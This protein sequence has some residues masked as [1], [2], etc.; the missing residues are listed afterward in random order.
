MSAGEL[1]LLRVSAAFHDVGK[2]GIPDTVLLKPGP[3]NDEEWAI[4]KTHS[5]KCHNIMEA[6]DCDES[7][8]IGQAV[9]H[10]H[11]RFDG[12]GYPDGLAGEAIPIL[13]RILMVADTYDATARR[14]V[15]ATAK[16]HR[17]SRA[18]L[19]EERGRQ[20]DPWLVDRF[21]RM[22][23]GSD[24]RQLRAPSSNLA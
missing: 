10:H 14:R 18:V 20:H 13:A 5:V 6:I 23:E 12:T 9:R 4:V 3:L 8:V 7:E 24:G 17:Q 16:P 1:K 11:E 15:Y 19:E 2:I 21:S 22:I